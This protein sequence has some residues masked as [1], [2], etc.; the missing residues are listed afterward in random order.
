VT[1]H[2]DFDPVRVG[3]APLVLESELRDEL[4]SDEPS[5]ALRRLRLELILMIRRARAWAEQ[6]GI[7][8]RFA[9]E[10]PPP[11]SGPQ[12]CLALL[13]DL[14][15]ALQFLGSRDESP[16]TMSEVV[17]WLKMN[18]SK[19]LAEL[20][21]LGEVVD[22]LASALGALEGAT[23]TLNE[24][25]AAAASVLDGSAPARGTPG[26]RVFLTS[27]TPETACTPMW[28]R[29]ATPAGAASRPAAS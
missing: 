19:A 17:A 28:S 11:E 3:G 29:A 25:L 24:T 4:A 10:T 22:E 9:P 23:R 1:D 12:Q 7:P 26:R 13:R 20:T 21:E 8:S 2:D 18:R 14:A 5:Q 15:A 6:R 16:S 27:S